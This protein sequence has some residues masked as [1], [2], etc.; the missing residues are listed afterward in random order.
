VH[1]IPVEWRDKCSFADLV[2]TITD[3]IVLQSQ[4][5]SA[6]AEKKPSLVYRR[7]LDVYSALVAFYSGTIKRRVLPCPKHYK[8]NQQFDE[9]IAQFHSIYET[10][11]KSSEGQRE[12]EE[13]GTDDEKPL[14]LKRANSIFQQFLGLI[15]DDKHLLTVKWSRNLSHLQMHKHLPAPASS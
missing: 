2:Q 13:A 5:L 4:Q 10:M 3:E 14:I 12:G 7:V 11:V 9:D 15:E 1:T 6:T 8:S